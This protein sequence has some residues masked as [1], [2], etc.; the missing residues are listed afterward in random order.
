MYLKERSKLHANTF[1]I[2]YAIQM[3]LHLY[4]LHEGKIFK[5]HSSCTLIHALQSFLPFNF[6]SKGSG[7]YLV[8]SM[9]SSSFTCTH[10]PDTSFFVCFRFCPS[11]ESKVLKFP[12][13]RHQI[14][15]EPEG[16]VWPFTRHD[17][18]TKSV[19]HK[20]YYF[21]WPSYN[22]R[23]YVPLILFFMLVSKVKVSILF[24]IPR[25]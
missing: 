19:Y 23:S 21:S 11:L 1:Y 25:P 6:M 20:K 2:S 8:T 14:W 4:Y 9:T 3:K 15:L 5:T 16:R 13:R 17:A 22:H 7:V 24:L 10:G 18:K 12:G